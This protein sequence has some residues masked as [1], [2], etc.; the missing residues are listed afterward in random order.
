MRNTILIVL[1][2]L[3]LVVGGIGLFY[4]WGLPGHTYYSGCIVLPTEEDFSSFKMTFASPHVALL[5]I[6]FLATDPPIIVSFKAE[7]DNFD[8]LFPYGIKS[9]QG[10]YSKGGGGLVTFVLVGVC[11][12]LIG[13][14]SI[15]GIKVRG[16]CLIQ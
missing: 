14:A 6:S 1:A 11:I 4:L 9:I 3:V 12:L 2:V 15:G 10:Y 7:V 16:R 13:V 8:Y 5:S